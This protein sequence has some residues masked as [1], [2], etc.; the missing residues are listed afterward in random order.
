MNIKIIGRSIVLATAVCFITACSAQPE[1]TNI[2]VRHTVDTWLDSMQGKIYKATLRAQDGVSPLPVTA[3]NERLFNWK[4]GDISIGIGFSQPPTA[5][6][7]LQSLRT[8]FKHLA[9]DHI[10]VPGV[11]SK[12]WE[13]R[14][15]TPM[16]SF[17]D[18]V[19]LESWE[20]GVLLLRVQTTFF[21]AYGRDL[22]VKTPADAGMPEG[23]Y[24]QIRK[25]VKADLV[26]E[27][28]LF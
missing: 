15:R 13:T 21:A 23:S 17:K 14:L 27:G 25:P 19:S 4:D 2:D 1:N 11:A 9:L 7:T 26:I 6:S 28:R 10:P 24:F 16:S 3:V 12:R 20:N 22:S 8:S 18:G 5:Q